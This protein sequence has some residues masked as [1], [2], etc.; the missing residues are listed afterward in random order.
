MSN[1]PKYE[2]D[3][4]W[5]CE[6]QLHHLGVDWYVC[7]LD[8]AVIGRFSSEGSDYWSY[9]M[10]LVE[11]SLYRTA[12]KDSTGKWVPAMELAMARAVLTAYQLNVAYE[13]RAERPSRTLKQMDLFPK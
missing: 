2:H 8:N 1:E 9:A 10:D 4:C 5:K 3:Y 12:L 13:M 6:F 11:E 7:H